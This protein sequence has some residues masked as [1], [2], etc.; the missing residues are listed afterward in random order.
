MIRSKVVKNVI[1]YD[2]KLRYFVLATLLDPRYKLQCLPKQKHN[3]YR[4]WLEKEAENVAKSQLNIGQPLS[5]QKSSDSTAEEPDDFMELMQ[6]QMMGDED[7]LEMDNLEE[8]S[9]SAT[10][11][12]ILVINLIFYIEISKH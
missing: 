5:R 8:P 11:E 10:K 4:E 12:D 1:N 2:N 3:I 9:S 7:I 6:K